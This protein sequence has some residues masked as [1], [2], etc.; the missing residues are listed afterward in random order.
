MTFKGVGWHD[1]AEK[2]AKELI[3][4]AVRKHL[5]QCNVRSVVKM[6]LHMQ[7]KFK[8]RF[9][10]QEAQV[11]VLSNYWS[12]MMGVLN[13]LAHEQR[14]TA[15]QGTLR[16]IILIPKPVITHALAE[17]VKKCW[18][19]HSIAF[20]QWRHQFPSVHSDPDLNDIPELVT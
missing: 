18:E 4:K 10:V 2:R 17:F 19:L 3:L 1:I 13:Q 16:K 5:S 7:N 12:K 9:M 15:F 11:E 20:L 14:N 6:L 8:L